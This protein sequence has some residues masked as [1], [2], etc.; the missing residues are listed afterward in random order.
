MSQCWRNAIVTYILLTVKCFLHCG[1]SSEAYV[2]EALQ[3][4]ADQITN[5]EQKYPDYLL[6]VLGA[7]KQNTGAL[8]H[9]TKRKH[10]ALSPMQPWAL[11]SI[12]FRNLWV[13]GVKY[14]LGPKDFKHS[15]THQQRLYFLHQ[16][17]IQPGSAADTSTYT[18]QSLPSQ[19]SY[20]SLNTA[21]PLWS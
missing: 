4:L 15:L 3:H 6:I 21:S 11:L 1:S 14:L 17:E 2:S 7:Q 18:C 16:Q 5:M 8:L 20:V 12:N 19:S 9:N 13:S 10:I